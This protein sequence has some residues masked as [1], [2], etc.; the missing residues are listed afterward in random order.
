MECQVS[1]VSTLSW[2]MIASAVFVLIRQT[3]HGRPARYGR[4]AESRGSYCPSRAAWCLQEAPAFLVPLLLLLTERGAPEAAGSRPG[5]GRALLLLG[6]FMTHYFHRAFIYAFLTRGRPVPRYV[7]F[8]A[9]IFCTLN[10][11]LQAHFLLHC[12]HF[13]D[14]WLTDARLT[15]G[16]FLFVCGMVIN[17]HS[18]HI[19]R[20]LRKPDEVAYKIPRGGMFEWVSGANFL[21][22]IIEWCGYAIAVWSFPAFAFIFFTICSIGPR[23]YLHHRDYQ[24]RFKD[25]PPTRKAILPFLL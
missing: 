12:A 3:L 16:L 19:L 22:E 13:H 5:A 23:A 15:A 25:Y 6:S 10:S 24:K 7:V 8:S 17:I 20:G 1:A 11:A 4:Y 18:D 14:S 21:G 2:L 9:A